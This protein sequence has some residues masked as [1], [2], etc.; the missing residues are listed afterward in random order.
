VAKAKDV[1]GKVDS[2]FGYVGQA[3]GVANSL[4]IKG[5]AVDKVFGFLNNAK[6]TW[7]TNKGKIDQAAGYVNQAKQYQGTANTVLSKAQD[8]KSKLPFRF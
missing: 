3:Q 1:S 7:D 5:G 4:G 8:I 2:A 6:N